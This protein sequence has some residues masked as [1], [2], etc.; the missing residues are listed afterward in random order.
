MTG[1]ILAAVDL[2]HPEHHA[3]ILNQARKLA[4]LDDLPL[5]VV[6]VIPDFGMSIVASYFDADI[7]KMARKRAA[8]GLHT[9]VEAVLGP[10]QDR[11]IRHIVR[12]GKVY[13][14]ILRT[15][16]EQS[17]SVIVMGAHRPS[18]QDYL[19]GQ[20]AA[21]VVRHASCSVYILR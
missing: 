4:A 15:A 16:D 14:E 21:S 11:T 13:E 19:L 7:E 18:I 8:E 3:A 10:E 5:S 9:A 17:S 2:A 6:T 12:Q 20:N 1:V